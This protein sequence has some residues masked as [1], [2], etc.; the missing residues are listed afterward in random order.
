MCRDEFIYLVSRTQAKISLFDRFWE[1]KE[2][3]KKSEI[4]TQLELDC[5]CEDTTRQP[6]MRGVTAHSG[7]P[8]T[9]GMESLEPNLAKS[10]VQ[11]HQTK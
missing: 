10:L 2:S 7:P 6:S 9:R 1:T 5:D 8:D 11:I 3:R 4:S